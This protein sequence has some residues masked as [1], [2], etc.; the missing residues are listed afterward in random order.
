LVP[1]E[2]FR[3]NKAQWNLCSTNKH[4]GLGNKTV[5]RCDFEGELGQSLVTCDHKG[6]V[7]TRWLYFKCSTSLGLAFREMVSSSVHVLVENVV[8]FFY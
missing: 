8:L 5:Q 1:E 7:R 4:S 3:F 2:I 6:D